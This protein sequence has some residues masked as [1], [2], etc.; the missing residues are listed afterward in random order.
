MPSGKL[1]SRRRV[2]LFDGPPFIGDHV[3]HHEGIVAIVDAESR[4]PGSA[5]RLFAHVGEQRIQPFGF[6]VELGVAPVAGER[7]HHHGRH[8]PMMAT[9]TMSFDQR[10]AARVPRRAQ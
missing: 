6:L 7:D 2:V 5:V 8:Q 9:T 1:R 10:K 4:S 3:E